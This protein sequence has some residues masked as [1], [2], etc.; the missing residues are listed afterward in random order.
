MQVEVIVFALCVA[1]F[2]ALLLYVVLQKLQPSA[3]KR[4]FSGPVEVTP[5]ERVRRALISA[6]LSIRVKKFFGFTKDPLKARELKQKLTRAGYYGEK[7][8]TIFAICKVVAPILLPLFTIPFLWQVKVSLAVKPLLIYAPIALGFYLPNL[9]L[10][11][12]IQAR[13]QQLNEGL[14]DALDLLV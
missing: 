2:L 1:I 3:A 14:P 8:M 13:Q 11:H 6:Q 10:N 4:L 9:V 12:Q 7:A 5:T